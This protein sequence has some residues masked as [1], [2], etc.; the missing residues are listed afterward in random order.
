MLSPRIIATASPPMKSAP[1]MNASARPRGVAWAAYSK[2][3]PNCDPSP[4]RR[5]NWSWSSGVV[6]I[7]ISLIP[8]IISV[9]RG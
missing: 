1:M 5:R 3:Q 8:A 6:M 4:S 9:D 2:R 7:R